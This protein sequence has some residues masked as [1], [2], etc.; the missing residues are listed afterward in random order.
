MIAKLRRTITDE[1]VAAFGFSKLGWMRRLLAPVFWP[2]AHLFARLCARIDEI[3]SEYGLPAGARQLLPRFVEGVRISGKD[4]IPQEGPLLIAS[5]HP[6]AYDA[7]AILSNLERKDVKIIV[8]DVPFLHSLPAASRQMIFTPAGAH[9]RMTAVREMIRHM[10]AGGA[11]LIF[12]SGL[13]DPDP[14]ISPFSGVNLETWSPSLD[15]VVRKVPE[16][17]LLVSI[18]SGVLAPACLRS[19]LTRLID[20]PWRKQKLAEFLQVIQQLTLGR[21]F[22]LRPRITFGEP[23][24]ASELISRGSGEDLHLAILANARQVLDAH[25]SPT[26]A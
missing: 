12:P 8:S 7:L 5:N 19:P 15:L 1:I 20:E 23:L 24:T 17:R 10:Q 3:I 6:G 25:L 11:A 22:N 9:S 14:D 18:V 21:T 26:A 4:Q 2:P 13:V 16:T